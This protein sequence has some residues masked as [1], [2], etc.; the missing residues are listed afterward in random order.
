MSLL[1]ATAM[2]IQQAVRRGPSARAL[3][4]LVCPH[5]LITGGS[6]LIAID[7]AAR[8][9]DRGHDVVVYAPPGPLSAVVRDR[10]LEWHPAPP[11]GG[12]SV[13]PRVLRAMLRELG[14]FRPDIVHAY[15]SGP[16]LAAALAAAA[17]PTRL[18]VTVMSMHVPSHVPDDVPLIVGTARIAREAVARPGSVALME[19]PVDTAHD[20]PGDRGA[21]RDRLGLPADALVVSVVGRL[22][23]EHGKARGVIE[24]I[25]ELAGSGH[26]VTLVVAGTGDAAPE[27][28][29]AAATARLDV[30]LLGDVP[31]PRDVYDAAD[32]VFGMGA[33]A[34]RAMA[35]GRTL[36][37]QGEQGFWRL[38][39]PGSID[40]FLEDGF[41]GNG[42]TG[43]RIGALVDALAGDPGRRDSLGEFGRRLVL[44]RYAAARAAADM[45]ALYMSES[46]LP[47]H[48]HGEAVWR[49]L[50]RYARFRLAG[51]M[52][53]L[54]RAWR[55]LRGTHD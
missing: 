15:E 23:S 53:R 55:R 2:P 12:D 35:H 36:I 37:V 44:D 51:R 8:L 14:R 38:L 22:S 17:R 28:A 3:R 45:E 32:I 29:R 16:A 27:V 24:A 50:H 41:F 48:R 43:Q 21:A 18:I 4:V 39:E 7:L 25:G 13:R 40:G 5:E 31:D 10:G 54:H 6:Q 9:R 33:S 30:R 20:A 49:S 26:P 11:Y 34:L 42:P 1:T 19:P 52:P 46:A 47:A